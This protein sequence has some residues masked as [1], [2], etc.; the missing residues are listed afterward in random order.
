[1][2]RRPLGFW[3]ALCVVVAVVSFVVD[4]NTGDTTG[5]PYDDPY[6]NDAAFFAFWVSALAFGVLS[7]L[8]LWRWG[9]RTWG[10]N[11]T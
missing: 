3:I 6:Y 1:V 8:A 4:Q 5:P 11:T 10:R 2:R 9:R 7:A